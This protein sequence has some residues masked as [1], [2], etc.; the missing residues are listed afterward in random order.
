MTII[1]AAL[2]PLPPPSPA[3]APTSAGTKGGLLGAS[4][5]KSGADRGDEIVAETMLGIACEG[6]D[7]CKLVLLNRAL[8][9]RVVVMLEGRKR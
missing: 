9:A 5:G 7:E 3:H 1:R 8:L 6:E 2:H 4:A